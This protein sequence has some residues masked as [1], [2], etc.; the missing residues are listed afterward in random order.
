L[1]GERTIDS[2]Q[3]VDVWFLQSERLRT[4]LVECLAEPAESPEL[5][6]AQARALRHAS[7]E[8]KKS[9]RQRARRTAADK[10]R[11]KRA[12]RDRIF[13]QEWRHIICGDNPAP[14]DEEI[15]AAD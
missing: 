6:K 9:H 1:G 7:A 4:V 3:A 10:P 15:Q 13:K 8:Y 11:M 12:F 2:G 14:T 5:S